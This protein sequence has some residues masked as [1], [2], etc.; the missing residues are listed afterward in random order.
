MQSLIH[1]KFL[2]VNENACHVI[3]KMNFLKNDECDWF[4][5]FFLNSS[6]KSFD[7]ICFFA[8]FEFAT[9]ST[10]LYRIQIIVQNVAHQQFVFSLTRFWKIIIRKIH[11]TIWRIELKLSSFEFATSKNNAIFF[12]QHHF[13]CFAI[14]SLY[15]HQI[16]A[17]IE[18]KHDDNQH[19]M[20]DD[21]LFLKNSKT[22]TNSCNSF[23]WEINMTIMKIFSKISTFLSNVKNI[24]SILQKQKKTKQN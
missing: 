9:Q 18:M 14:K 15:F 12:N 23:H 11:F 13:S 19:D 17:Q 24:L 21:F 16:I 7:T 22:L 3:I 6:K 10:M 2:I 4:S 8:K 20:F 1:R 5:I